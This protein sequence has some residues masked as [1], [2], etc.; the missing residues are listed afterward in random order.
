VEPEEYTRGWNSYVEV[1]KTKTA[2]FA[3]AFLWSV[4]SSRCP[5]FHL[6]F[7]TET[8]LLADSGTGFRRYVTSS[9]VQLIC[10]SGNLPDFALFVQS[11]RH[12]RTMRTAKFE[13]GKA[14]SRACV[15]ALLAN[16]PSRG[17]HECDPLYWTCTGDQSRTLV[18]QELQ[19]NPASIS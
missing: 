9:S 14:L 10:R 8:S 19:P 17:N 18:I 1:S 6:S 2:R 16:R 3:S 13:W 4:Y 12:L 15:V 7:G 11:L 5:D